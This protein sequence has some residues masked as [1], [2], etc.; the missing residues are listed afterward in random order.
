MHSNSA[1][2]Y[3]RTEMHTYVHQNTYKMAWGSTAQNSPKPGNYL[4]DQQQHND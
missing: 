2:R 3:K 1:V 4:N